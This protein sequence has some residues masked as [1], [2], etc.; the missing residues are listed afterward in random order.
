MVGALITC[1]LALSFI[2][3]VVW[4]FSCENTEIQLCHRWEKYVFVFSRKRSETRMS[5]IPLLLK[6]STLE[7]FPLLSSHMSKPSRLRLT[8][9]CAI[10]HNLWHTNSLTVR[11]FLKLLVGICTFWNMSWKSNQI[12][13]KSNEWLLVIPA[14]AV[15]ADMNPNT[16]LSG[17]VAPVSLFRD[18]HRN[19]KKEHSYLWSNSETFN[20]KLGIFYI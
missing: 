1:D 20:D 3:A 6:K 8:T 14:K 2:S 5:A 7:T 12:K 15:I 19:N 13:L 4:G 9:N 18:I 10:S 16:Q 11:S 17:G